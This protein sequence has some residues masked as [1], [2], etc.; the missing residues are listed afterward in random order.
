MQPKTKTVMNKLL[1]TLAALLVSGLTLA[2]STDKNYVKSTTYE[3]PVQ[4]QSEIDALP[5]DDKQESIT[6]YDG[7]GRPQQSIALRAGGL[8]NTE[9]ENLLT[10]DWSLGASTTPSFYGYGN[11]PTENEII[12]GTTPFG[13]EDLIWECSNIDGTGVTDGINL[14]RDGGWNTKWYAI[15]NTQSYRYTTWVKRTHSTTNGRLYFGPRNVSDLSGTAQNNPYFVQNIALPELDTWYLL[16]GV[17]HPVGYI[18]GDTDQSG[19]YDMNG[20][21]IIN[22]QEFKWNSSTTQSRF[23]NLMYGASDL[24]VKQYFYN[25]ILQIINGQELT[26]GQ[27]LQGSTA[28]DIVTPIVYD[29]FGRQAKEYLPYAHNNRAA[30]LQLMSLLLTMHTIIMHRLIQRIAQGNSINAL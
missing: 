15:D 29:D 19:I 6:Y 7:L 20:N 21:K 14:N 8:P 24:N 30:Y 13:D 16:V 3:A 4:S 27:Q 10:M 12:T 1:Y 28:N 18:G 26:I 17:V 25:P 11:H 22:G 23:R 5:I 2:Q 9:P